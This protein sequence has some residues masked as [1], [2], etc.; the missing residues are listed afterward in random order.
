MNLIPPINATGIYS[1][2]APFSTNYNMNLSYNCIA[3]RKIEDI[4][5]LGIDPFVTYYSPSNITK[6]RYEAD[7]LEDVCI[8]TLESE[9]GDHI[10]VPTTFI[11]SYPNVN[12][13]PYNNVA[14]MLYLGALPDSMNLDYVKTKLISDVVGILGITPT[15]ETVVT[16]EKTLLSHDNHQVAETARKA[17]IS[18]T[19][20]E[21]AE[22]MR[23]REQVQKLTSQIVQLE[24]HILSNP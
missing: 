12:G 22:N 7:L 11:V 9:S 19:N 15:V 2:S 16:S 13:V 24:T 5:K 17:Q 4:I 6:E 3:V 14:L 18:I 10:Y 21:Y 8:V 23:L 20:T 1:L